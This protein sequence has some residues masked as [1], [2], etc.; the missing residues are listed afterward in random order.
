MLL[1][2]LSHCKWKV[3]WSQLH[4][5]IKYLLQTAHFSK[6]RSLSVYSIH[7]EISASVHAMN[8]TETYRVYAVPNITKL[9]MKTYKLLYRNKRFELMFSSTIKLQTS[10]A[11]HVNP[12]PPHSSRGRCRV[13]AV[14]YVSNGSDANGVLLYA[15]KIH[16][17]C[18]S[19]RHGGVFPW[20]I[21]L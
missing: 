18:W 10:T 19:Y 7:T 5:G 12:A 13:N 4:C 20:K 9:S 17:Q 15:V 21:Y 3:K 1:V 6:C 11:E 8:T 2:Y 14:H 16:T